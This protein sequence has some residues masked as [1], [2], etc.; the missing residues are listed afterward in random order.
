M[1]LCIYSL[2]IPQPS[3]TSVVSARSNMDDALEFS[4]VK[5]EE[6]EEENIEAV[7]LIRRL[8]ILKEV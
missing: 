5:F 7:K 3:L 2:T 1:G 4:E 8:S 6:E